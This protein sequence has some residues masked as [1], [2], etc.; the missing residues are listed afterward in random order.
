[1]NSK[2]LQKMQPTQVGKYI[3]DQMELFKRMGHSES[4]A[5]SHELVKMDDGYYH[6][7]KRDKTIEIIDWDLEGRG[8]MIA[9]H[10]RMRREGF[11]GQKQK[12]ED[13]LWMLGHDICS[14]EVGETQDTED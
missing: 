9:Q 5:F 1:M 8:V 12:E 14:V 4:L 3:K 10:E 2:M 7:R 13:Q 6:L 11:F